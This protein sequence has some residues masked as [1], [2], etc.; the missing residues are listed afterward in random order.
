MKQKCIVY[1]LILLTFVPLFTAH[2]AKLVNIGVIMDGQTEQGGWTPEQFKSE[3]KALTKGEF[4]LRFPVAKQLDGNWSAKRIA[5]AFKQLQDD[6]DV[7]MVITLG[8]VS[9]AVAILNRPL[10]KPTFA[11]FVWDANLLGMNIKG[12]TSGIRNLNFLGGKASFEHDLKTFRSVVEFHKLAILI[13][14][15]VYD[16]LPGLIQRAHDVATSGG[17]ELHFIMQTTQDEDLASK[18]PEDIDAVV[19]T[20]LP[21]LGAVAMNRLIKALIKKRLPSYSLIGSHLV[22][23]GI[24]MAEAPASDW[25]R[26]ARRNA[27]NMYAVLKGEAAE[28]Q[29]VTFKGKRRLTLNMATARAIDL[30]PR[31]DIMHKAIL[32]NEEPEPT[33]RSITL[34]TVAHEAVKANLDLRA[35]ALGLEGGQ[36]EIDEARA[37]LLPQLR[38]GIGYSQLNDDS[39]TVISGAAAEQSTMAALT[40]TQLIYSDVISTNVQ[41]QHYFQN[42]RK[43]LYRQ[44]ELDIIQDATLAYLNIL[45]AQTLVHIRRENAN[46]TRTNLRLAQDRQRLGVGK[47]AEVYRWQS[48]LA[49]SKK[50]LLGAQAQHQQ[51]RDVLSRLLHRSFKESFI[52]TSASLDD[53]SLLVSR[54]EL[55]DYVNKDRAYELMGDFMVKE[56]LAASPEMA[57]L[58]ALVSAS[59][60]ELKLNQRAYWSPTVTFQGEVSN[61]LD[62]NRQAGLSA[63]DETDWSVGIN[64]SLPLFEGGARRAR[65]SGSRLALEKNNIQRDATAGRIEQGIRATLHQIKA[66]YPSIQLSREAAIAARKNLELV[67]DAY[68]RGTLSIIDLLD[69]QNAALVAE[70][71]ATNAEFDFLIDLMNLQRNIGRFDFFLDEQGLDDWLNRLRI[72]IATEGKG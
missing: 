72:Y 58:Q 5:A 14:S 21:R 50:E 20:S 61:V 27:L 55:F 49:T 40:L 41:I 12:N 63:E 62:E 54:K 67:T 64:V 60:L 6:P 46:L 42:N 25:Q 17:V 1:T 71:S 32:L 66:S 16:A 65:V 11:P 56:A 52:T 31:Y 22:E 19:V 7:N 23:Q 59:K 30:S 35:T 9:S 36:T 38:A 10:R 13:D 3:L 39:T 47:P 43:A 57:G 24:L 33:G 8:Y 15:S 18:L 26:L 37:K 68:T 28:N 29:P 4:E 2:A 70:E 48:E 53:P 45:K 44:L 51:A 69:A 34:S